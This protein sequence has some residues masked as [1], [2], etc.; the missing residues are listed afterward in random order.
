MSEHQLWVRPKLMPPPKVTD[1]ILA[2]PP[3]SGAVRT[4]EPFQVLSFAVVAVSV[5]GRTLRPGVFLLAAALAAGTVRAAAPL[6]S[7]PGTVIAVS[8][9]SS[10]VFLALAQPRDSAR[11]CL[12]RELRHWREESARRPHRDLHFERP[13]QDLDAARR[14]DRPALVNALHAPRRALAH[15]RVNQRRPHPDPPLD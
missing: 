9:N 7:V 8:S 2:A 13:R 14:A 3:L 6:G 11:G 15:G 5:A 1:R 10:T 4:Y 12:R